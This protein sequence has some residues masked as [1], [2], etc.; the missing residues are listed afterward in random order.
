MKSG[1]NN[2][3]NTILSAKDK[4]HKNY[5]DNPTF[6]LGTKNDQNTNNKY[7]LDMVENDHEQ[8]L[9]S[10]STPKVIKP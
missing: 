5:H 10:R 2:A 6:K 9:V 7:N 1:L 4:L 8:I 3:K